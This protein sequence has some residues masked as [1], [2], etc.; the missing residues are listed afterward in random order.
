[1]PEFVVRVWA[2]QSMT[3]CD[4]YEAHTAQEALD[5][6]RKDW[7]DWTLE[8]VDESRPIGP[9]H[10]VEVIECD[11]DGCWSED[12]PRWHADSD[13]EFPIGDGGA[14]PELIRQAQTPARGIDE[15]AHYRSEG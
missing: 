7:N 8:P 5:L 1:M 13:E 2:I 3:G 10:W 14:L 15:T 6:A 9:V 11:R 12:S 4:Q